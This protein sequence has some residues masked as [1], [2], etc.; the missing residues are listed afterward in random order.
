MTFI[1]RFLIGLGLSIMGLTTGVLLLEGALRA[2]QSFQP[3][4]PPPQSR[5]ASPPKPGLLSFVDPRTGL[6]LPNSSG[7]TNKWTRTANQGSWTLDGYVEV[8]T[9]S[10]GMRSP[11]VPMPKAR[12]TYRIL[13]LGDSIVFGTGLDAADTFV[14]RLEKN[15]QAGGRRIEIVNAGVGDIGSKEEWEIFQSTGI[16]VQPDIVLVGFYLNDARS[17]IRYFDQQTVYRFAGAKWLDHQSWFNRSLTVQKAHHLADKYAA[18]R[19][20][21]QFMKHDARFQWARPYTEN[22]EAWLNDEAKFMDVVRLARFDWGAA[23]Q[24]ETW[25]IIYDYIGRM[26]Q[27]CQKNNIRLAVVI[28]PAEPQLAVPARFKAFDKPQRVLAQWLREKNIPYLDMLR[29]LRESRRDSQD[30]M[31]DQCHYTSAGSQ[32]VAANIGRFLRSTPGLLK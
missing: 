16:H 30:L 25:P 19:D 28:L 20:A 1:R 32:I 31:F 12:G 23:W 18:L 26:L 3:P 2:A 5:Q 29:P 14:R 10:L 7:Y 6:N 8:R 9:N 4:P 21:E 15:L 17:P 13:F 22:R 24:D 11:E 27:L